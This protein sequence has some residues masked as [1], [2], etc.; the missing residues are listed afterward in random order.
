MK[1]ITFFILFKVAGAHIVLY[2][3]QETVSVDIGDT[4]VIGCVSNDNLESGA[5]IN[6]Y[7]ETW[8]PGDRYILAISCLNYKDNDYECEHNRYETKLKIHKAKPKDSGVYYCTY[9]FSRTFANG[10]FLIVEEVSQP[11]IPIHLLVHSHYPSINTAIQLVCT[12]RVTSRLVL[13]TWNISGTYQ[14]GK[15]ISTREPGGAWIFQNLLSLPKGFMNYGDHVT[16][17][18]W[19]ST[20]PVQVHWTIPERD[21]TEEFIS[22]CQSLALSVCLILLLTLVV[23]LFWTYKQKDKNA[24]EAEGKDR[25]TSVRSYLHDGIVYAHLD[26]GQ[27]TQGRK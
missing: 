19:F 2:Q 5:R 23:H 7:Q 8:T 16:C 18:V 11:E 15:M 22:V 4:A 3:P 12:V 9:G 6:W 13:I 14:K 27:I 10:T 24:Q 26:M 1:L 17:E 25:R 20:S 21:Q